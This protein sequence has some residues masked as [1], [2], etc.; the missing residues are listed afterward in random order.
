MLLSNVEVLDVSAEVA[1][2]VA[3]ADQAV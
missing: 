1:P 2:R 3:V